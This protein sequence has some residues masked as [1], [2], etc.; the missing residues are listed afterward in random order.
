[1][2]IAFEPVLSIRT[3]P[4]SKMIPAGFVCEMTG[5]PLNVNRSKVKEKTA[6]PKVIRVTHQHIE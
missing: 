6:G 2:A 4:E 5:N 1:M 3:A